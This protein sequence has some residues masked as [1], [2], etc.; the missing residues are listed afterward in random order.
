MSGKVETSSQ[1]GGIYEEAEQNPALILTETNQI[2][3]ENPQAKE[4]MF[5][6]IMKGEIYKW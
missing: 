3:K 2:Q 1:N 6:A 4:K 5:N